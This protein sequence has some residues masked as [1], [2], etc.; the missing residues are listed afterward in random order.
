MEV[1]VIPMVG[2]ASS[3]CC[4]YV[5]SSGVG[6]FINGVFYISYM[7]YMVIGHCGFDI[8]LPYSIGLVGMVRIWSPC[9]PS[10]LHI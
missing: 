9:P 8:E 4:C 1:V 6:I 2:S 10:L 7:I 3:F 5:L